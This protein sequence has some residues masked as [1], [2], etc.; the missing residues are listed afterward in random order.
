MVRCFIT[1]ATGFFGSHIVNQLNMRDYHVSIL[2]RSSSNFDL[3][4]GMTI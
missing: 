2:A 1:G 4:D 3:L